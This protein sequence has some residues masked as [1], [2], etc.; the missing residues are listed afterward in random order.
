MSRFFHSCDLDLDPMTL[1]HELDL[2]ILKMYLR[3]KYELSGSRL[4]KVRAL[5]TDRQTD[6]QTDIEMHYH[7]AFM[8]SNKYCYVRDKSCGIIRRHAAGPVTFDR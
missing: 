2:K 7:A 1:I 5:Q 3:I 8:D 4:S 6:R